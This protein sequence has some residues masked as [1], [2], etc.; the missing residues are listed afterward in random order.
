MA[1]RA[2]STH[3]KRGPSLLYVLGLVVIAAGVVL[4]L[5]SFDNRSLRPAG[6][7]LLLIGVVLTGICLTSQISSGIYEDPLA[8]EPPWTKLG[9]GHGP[10]RLPP[11]GKP[12]A[13]E[14]T[15]AIDKLVD[16]AAP[17]AVRPRAPVKK[18]VASPKAQPGWKPEIFDYV[19]P[20]Q[21]DAICEM[22]FSQSG[23]ETR[24]QS[25]GLPGGV[26]LWLHSRNAQQGKD[27]PVSVA[28]CKLWP[29]QPLL[30]RDLRPLLDGMSERGIKRATYATGSSFTENASEFA[31]S[32]GINALDRFGLLKLIATRTPEQQQALLAV[33]LARR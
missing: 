17:D 1:T 12:A 21:F 20:L 13:P 4:L 16:F 7:V 32:N 26:I 24:V 14:S 31:K 6:G 2:P 5:L 23:L 25:H 9:K 10:P 33:A 3:A 15:F 28:F 19:T 29:G 30:V 11:P 22:L 27:N 8:Y 18:S